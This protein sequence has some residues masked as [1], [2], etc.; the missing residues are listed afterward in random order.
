MPVT[1]LAE[2]FSSFPRTPPPPFGIVITGAANADFRC[3]P[4]PERPGIDR[5]ASGE[6]LRV[7]DAVSVGADMPP[8]THELPTC[9]MSWTIN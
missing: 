5:G 1:G 2:N 3:L 6:A 8:T 7:A 4:C 9:A